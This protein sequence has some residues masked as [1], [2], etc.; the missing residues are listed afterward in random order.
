MVCESPGSSSLYRCCGAAP[1]LGSAPPLLLLVFSSSFFFSTR[2]NNKLAYFSKIIQRLARAAAADL[3][4][5]YDRWFKDWVIIENYRDTWDSL[6]RSTPS[7]GYHVPTTCQRGRT[8]ALTSFRR[9]ASNNTPTSFEIL[10][11]ILLTLQWQHLC[12][13]LLS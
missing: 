13:S 2:K 11:A 4:T 6:W 3:C 1:R 9:R 12:R 10:P 5:K 7:W 8:N